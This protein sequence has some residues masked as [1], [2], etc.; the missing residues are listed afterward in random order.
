[1]NVQKLYKA[2]FNI[3]NDSDILAKKNAIWKILCN[4]FFIN[5][6]P[7]NA[8]IVDIGAGYCEFINNIEIKEERERERECLK[9]AVD[10]NPD[11]QKFAHPDVQVI[12]ADCM[13]IAELETA[14]CDVVFMSNF[15]EHL[16]TRELILS[17]FAECRR[18]LKKNGRLLILQPNIRY[19]GMAYYDFFDHHTALTDKSLVEALELSGF[20]IEDCIPRFL[21]YTTKSHLPQSP[22]LVTLYLKL[23][24]AWKIF[25]KQCF[26]SAIRDT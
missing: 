3:L 2:R 24:F 19:V 22:W 5:Y 10:I 25:G 23:P 20:A 11:T 18:L 13:N 14:S 21:P 12:N 1:M 26:I 9:I 15:L 16:P 17:L 8:T 7:H 4:E 6:I